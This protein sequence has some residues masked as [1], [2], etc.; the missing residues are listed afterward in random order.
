[1]YTFQVMVM[2]STEAPSAKEE[3][4]RAYLCRCFAEGTKT[5]NKT[6]AQRRQVTKSFWSLQSSYQRQVER[7][8]SITIDK[9]QAAHEA[10]GFVFFSTEVEAQ[11]AADQMVQLCERILDEVYGP[12]TVVQERA[13]A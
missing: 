7:T 1:M 4:V 11:A 9:V 13:T 3:R 2:G 10:D 12:N 6:W 8:P 5:K